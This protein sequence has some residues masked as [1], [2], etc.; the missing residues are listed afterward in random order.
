MERKP[1]LSIQ[2][3]ATLAAEVHLLKG[4]EKKFP[5]HASSEIICALKKQTLSLKVLIK[6]MKEK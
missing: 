4:L 2:A 3:L 5:K 6:Q 1:S